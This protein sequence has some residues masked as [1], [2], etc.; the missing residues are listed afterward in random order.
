MLLIN[1]EINLF[2]TWS[3]TWVLSND[4]KVTSFAIADT[5][6]YNCNS[7]NSLVQIRF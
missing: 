7:I 6:P 4:A 5:K 2:L 3:D 1:C